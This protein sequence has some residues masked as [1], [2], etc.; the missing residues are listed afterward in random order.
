MRVRSCRKKRA[1]ADVKYRGP[2]DLAHLSCQ[3]IDRSSFIRCLCYDAANAYMV[4]KLRDT[5][6][7]YCGI[8]KATVEAFKAADSIGRFFNESIKGHF[9]VGPDTSR[10]IDVPPMRRCGS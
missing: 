8:D 10:R 7:H 4:V 3:A 1:S 2:V 9:D 6:Y 5:Y